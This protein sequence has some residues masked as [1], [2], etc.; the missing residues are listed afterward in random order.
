VAETTFIEEV[1]ALSCFLCGFLEATY[2]SLK[3]AIF[4]DN[5]CTRC[6][7]SSGD[8]A[9]DFFV[10]FFSNYD[11]SNCLLALFIFNFTDYSK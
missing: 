7:I 2:S 9:V 11:F 8:Y 6:T 10:I 1:N 3:P 4:F 5:F